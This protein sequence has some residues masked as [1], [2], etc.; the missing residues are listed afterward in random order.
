MSDLGE[1]FLPVATDEDAVTGIPVY[2]PSGPGSVSYASSVVDGSDDIQ[3]SSAGA[4]TGFAAG[5]STTG[6]NVSSNGDG[7]EEGNGDSSGRS[8]HLFLNC[9]CDCRR[10]VLIVN[11]IAI[12][13]KI[14][15]M[16]VV[17]ILGSYLTKNIDSI[18][19]E[20]ADDE[21]R[22]ELD[23]MMKEGMVPV[24]EA[25]LDILAIVG[26]GLAMC[27]IYGALKF[28]K[29]GI[30]TAGSTYALGLLLGLLTLDFFTVTLSALCLYPH[31]IMYKEMKEG[32]MT[33]LNYHKIARCCG[34]RNM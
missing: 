31:V 15:S 24:L 4:G 32:I 30:I 7:I 27:G 9:C 5:S 22:K 25:F 21:F 33:E 29:W 2:H 20:M 16:I 17:G 12:G 10:A 1:K 14:L 18:E 3:Y 23:E 11:G 26:I 28:K 8:S 34:D 13:L 6:F 19:A